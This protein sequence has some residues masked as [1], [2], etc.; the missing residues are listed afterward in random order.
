MTVLSGDDF[1]A[2]PLYA[3]GAR[4]VISV[5]SNVAPRWM[6]EMW[7][8]ARAGDYARARALH[9]RIQPL[10]ELLFAETSPIPTK[11]ALSLMGKLT[12]ELRPPLY[13]MTSAGRERMRALLAAEGLL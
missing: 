9:F 12:D 6:A 5:A 13:P 10:T 7:D 2:Y 3:V 4:G 8:A 11:C 1:T